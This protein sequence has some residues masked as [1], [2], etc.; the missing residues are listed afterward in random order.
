M[1]WPCFLAPF[2]YPSHPLNLLWV[3]GLV[4]LEHQHTMLIEKD[5][6]ITLRDEGYVFADIFWPS[7]INEQYP[8]IFTYGP[9]C[10]D[11]HFSDFDPMTYSTSPV[12]NENMVWETPD[13]ETW[14]KDGYIVVRIDQ[15]G[16]GKSPGE[17]RILSSTFANDLY[18]VIE[19]LGTQPWSSGKV[20]ML[21]VSYYAVSQWI[22]AEMN[23]PHLVP[24]YPGKDLPMLT[25][26]LYDK[27]EFS[28]T[29]SS[30]VG[31]TTE[32]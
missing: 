1:L 24:S 19:W 31:I 30:M 21:G 16:S 10:K 22:A 11:L 14:V 20:G 26:M 25:A 27:E 32:S 28:T 12:Q 15:R 4:L 7:D 6:S 5:Q 2:C 23:P 17:V 8:V 9:Y 18:D 29:L 13:P 3:K